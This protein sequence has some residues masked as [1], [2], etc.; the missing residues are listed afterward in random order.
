MRADSRNGELSSYFDGALSNN[1][2]SLVSGKIGGGCG[3]RWTGGGREWSRSIEG[4]VG[5]YI[6]S[7]GGLGEGV[8]E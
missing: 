7:G 4:K 5:G 2:N 6:K 8:E 1:T 3:K